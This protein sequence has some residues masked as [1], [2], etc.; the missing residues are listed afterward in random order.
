MEIPL[1]TDV[2]DDAQPLSSSRSSKVPMSYRL[3]CYISAWKAQSTLYGAM[4][5]LQD[6][7]EMLDGTEAAQL[8]NGKAH[9]NQSSGHTSI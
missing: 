1:S 8:E 3:Q 9:T 7:L 6:S 4:N 2:S 5:M